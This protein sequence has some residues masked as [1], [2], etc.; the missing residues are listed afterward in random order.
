MH[1]FAVEHDLTSVEPLLIK[2][3]LV[4]QS[5]ALF[6]EMEDL[7]ENDRTVIR[8]ELTHRFKLPRT[9]YFTIILNSVAAAI[10]GWD[11]TGSNGANLTFGQALGIPDSGAEC[12][13]AGN[14]E[15]NGWIIGFVNACP[16]IA[17]AVFCAWIS[18]KFSLP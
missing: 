17:I 18:G 15:K 12:E 11:Q 10:Q 5:P 6:E 4:A 9:L 14:C 13:A 16:Y 8:E 3:A 1:D 2:G 7:D